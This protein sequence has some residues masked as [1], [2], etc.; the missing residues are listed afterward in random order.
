[1]AKSPFREND[2]QTP[3]LLLWQVTQEWQ[4]KINEVLA[5]HEIPHAQF[6][7]LVIILWHTINNEEVTQAK[8]AQMSH[9]DKMTVSKSLRKLEADRLVSREA[10]ISDSRVWSLKLT[11]TGLQ[12][13]KRLVRQAEAADKE[14]FGGLAKSD[15][16]VLTQM[17]A[18]L[19]E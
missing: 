11:K 8:L 13:A 7:L 12:T 16:K 14:F 9:L 10:H 18:I 4:R 19:A 2:K 6:V 17:L 3:G 5:P 1:M 15:Q